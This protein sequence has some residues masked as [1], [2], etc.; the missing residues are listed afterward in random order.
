MPLK[1]QSGI[2]GR[3]FSFLLMIYQPGAGI[4]I[5]ADKLSNPP[6]NYTEFNLADLEK[7]PI[8]KKQR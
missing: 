1:H 4:M 3:P 5:R 2:S 7:Y 8:L 6:E